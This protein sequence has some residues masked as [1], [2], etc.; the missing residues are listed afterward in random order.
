MYPIVR[1]LKDAVIASRQPRLAPLDTH[2]S[3]HHCWPWDIDIWMELNNGRTLTLYDLG[4]TMLT[5]R[6]GLAGVLKREGWAVAVAGTSIRYR[7]RIKAFERFEMKSRAIGWDAR[8]IYVEQGMW[9]ANGDCANHALLRTVVTD[10]NGIVPPERVI[11]AW[12]QDINS[13]TLP[14]WVQAWCDA[15]DKRP[16]PPM[17]DEDAGRDDVRLASA[18]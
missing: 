3:R 17:A 5:L 8:F 2:V 12:K 11:K 9:K 13:P 4:R 16:W 10:N 18:S 1:L 7:R 6:T 15:E 14:D